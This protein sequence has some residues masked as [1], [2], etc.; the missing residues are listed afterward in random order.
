MVDINAAAMDGSQYS[1]AAAGIPNRQPGAGPVA[2]N[3][4]LAELVEPIDL[5]A[6]ISSMRAASA[7]VE[8]MGATW[9]MVHDRGTM[10][11]VG[12]NPTWL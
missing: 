7:T 8:A 2:P 4:E 1:N 5:P 3:P 6:M 12:T 10:P 11:S 9:S